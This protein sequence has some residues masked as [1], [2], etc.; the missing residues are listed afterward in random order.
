MI[1]ITILEGNAT[2][3]ACG[4][5]IKALADGRYGR[6]KAYLWNRDIDSLVAWI[7]R[8]KQALG[9]GP[10]QKAEIRVVIA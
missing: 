5:P 10:N 1:T 8:D 3:K 9:F 4:W 2:E 7:E 6:G